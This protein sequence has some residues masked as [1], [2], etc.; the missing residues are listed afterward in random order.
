MSKKGIVNISGVSESRSALVISNIVK[1]EGQSLILTATLARA[2]RLAAD[3]SF[4]SEKEIFILPSEDQ[5]FLRYE[6]KN[7]DQ[8]IE[9]LKILKA[10][11]TKQECIVIAPVSAAIKKITPHRNFES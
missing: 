4:F 6:A 11:R 2:K 7:H 9:R 10:L 5:V 3:L 1:E 8:L